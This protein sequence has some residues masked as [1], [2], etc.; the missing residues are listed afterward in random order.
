MDVEELGT[1]IIEKCGEGKKL[2]YQN[3]NAT[4]NVS[5]FLYMLF[6]SSKIH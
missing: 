1:A 4:V 2:K 6:F 3:P 5:F